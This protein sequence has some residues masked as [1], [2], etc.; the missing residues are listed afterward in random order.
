MYTWS[1]L[2]Y[3]DWFWITCRFLELNCAGQLKKKKT[4]SLSLL[5]PPT[6]TKT[7]KRRREGRWTFQ[8]QFQTKAFVLYE[9]CIL[10]GYRIYFFAKMQIVLSLSFFLS[11]SWVKMNV[12]LL[13]IWCGPSNR[14]LQ[15]PVAKSAAWAGMPA[16]AEQAMPGE[17]KTKNISPI[18]SKDGRDIISHPFWGGKRKPK[19][20]DNASAAE[21]H[22]FHFSFILYWL[23]CILLIV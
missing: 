14:H 2:S 5:L 12:S 11:F 9:S 18:W 1:E 19:K 6:E 8:L 23:F 21:Q 15:A 13:E 22:M 7:K 4:I 3:E 17:T 20:R 10:I 16:R